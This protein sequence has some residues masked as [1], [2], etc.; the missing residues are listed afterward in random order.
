VLFK[1][2]DPGSEW[3]VEGAAV[4]PADFGTAKTTIT[5]KDEDLA[6][7]SAGDVRGLYQHGKLRVDGDVSVAHRLGLLKGL[8]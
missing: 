4:S 1:I 3:T 8:L 7:L 2:V 5:L 6:G